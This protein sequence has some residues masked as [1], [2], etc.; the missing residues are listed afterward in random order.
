[1]HSVMLFSLVID[2]PSYDYDYDYDHS[3]TKDVNK[4]RSFTLRATLYKHVAR[5]GLTFFLFLVISV[6]L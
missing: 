4:Q 6:A 5:Q 3:F 2:Q 1:M